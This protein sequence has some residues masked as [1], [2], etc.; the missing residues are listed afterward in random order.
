MELDLNIKDLEVTYTV[1]VTVASNIVA[2]GADLTPL[3]GQAVGIVGSS[4]VSLVP[5]GVLVDVRVSCDGG[6]EGVTVEGE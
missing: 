5:A 2:S 1:K 4:I 3:F 6:V